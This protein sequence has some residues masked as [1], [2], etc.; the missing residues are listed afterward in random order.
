[1]CSPVLSHTQLLCSPF[2]TRHSQSGT[3]QEIYAEKASIEMLTLF[4]YRRQK[5]FPKGE[6][7]EGICVVQAQEE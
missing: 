3:E 6:G 4:P 7:F 2:V 1:M 5:P